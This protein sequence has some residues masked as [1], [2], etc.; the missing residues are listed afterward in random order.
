M[1]RLKRE[2]RMNNLKANTNELVGQPCGCPRPKKDLT[3]NEISLSNYN[4]YRYLQGNLGIAT[5]NKKAARRTEDV[6]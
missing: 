5:P 3:M 1:V 2:I 4:I 6:R